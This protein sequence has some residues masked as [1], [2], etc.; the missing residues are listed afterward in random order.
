MLKK[1][2]KKGK[3]MSAAE[4]LFHHRGYTATSLADI[5]GEAG[6][7]LGNLYYY[8]RTKEDLA[9]AVIDE[10]NRYVRA[11]HESFEQKSSPLDRL[12]AFLERIHEAADDRTAHGCPVGGLNQ[13]ANKLGGR[14]AEDAAS[15]F[16]IMLAWVADQFKGLGFKPKQAAEEAVALI[17][18]IQGSILLGQ[19]MKDAALIRREIRRQQEQL[20]NRV[21]GG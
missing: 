19:T 16:K 13:E 10:R 5:A 21:N 2:E 4:T 12:L 11:R 20:K 1:A 15:T 14:L 3:V 6:I 8:F 18:A 9:K 7:P 17:A